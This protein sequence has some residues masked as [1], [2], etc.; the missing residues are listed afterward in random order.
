VV[1][2]ADDLVWEAHVSNQRFS[3][4]ACQYVSVL[5][6]QHILQRWHA[7][8]LTSVSIQHGSVS[9]GQ[10]AKIGTVHVA[11]AVRQVDF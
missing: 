11:C 8:M 6:C 7:D 4:S 9:A 5:Y 10:T 3:M 2:G 1:F